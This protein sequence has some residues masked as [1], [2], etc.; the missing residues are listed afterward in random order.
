MKRGLLALAFLLGVSA[1]S[2]RADYVVIVAN[3]GQGGS[4]LTTAGGGGV[5]GGS[6]ARGNILGGAPAG[7][8]LGG[9][10]GA[11]VRGAFGAAGGAAGLPGGVIGAAPG[12]GARGA[13]PGLPGAAMLGGGPPG[14]GVVGGLGAAG[15]PAGPPVRPTFDPDNVPVMI[16]A[17]V[18]VERNLGTTDAAMLEVGRHIKVQHKWGN[19][20]L[21]N[22]GISTV[23]F[24]HLKNNKGKLVA[25]LPFHK[26]YENKVAA[27]RESKTPATA[28]QYVELAE[29]TLGHGMLAKFKEHL[30]KVAEMDKANAKGAAYLQMKAALAKPV[31]RDESAAWRAKLLST[32]YL[33]L[34]SAHYALLHNDPAVAQDRIGRLEE[35]FQLYYYWFAM[36]GLQLPV[37]EERVVAIL[38]SDEKD[39]KRLHQHLDA[40]PIVSDS[41]Y[42]RHE[43]IAVFS[44]KRLDEVYDR[45]EK[46]STPLWSQSFNREQLLKGKY[47]RTA[48]V[49][50]LYEASTLAL[51]LQVMQNDADVAGAT[52]GVSRQLLF[53]SSLLPRGVVAPEWLQFGVG[54]FFETT[55]GSP[56]PTVGEPNFEYLPIYR[57]LDGAKKLPSDRVETIRQVVTD[58]FFRN[59]AANLDEEANLRKARST[60]WSLSYFL[61]RKRLD[62]MQRYVKELSKMPRDLVLD[63]QLLWTAFA[64]AFDALD[65]TGRPDPAALKRLAEDWDKDMKIVPEESAELMKAIREAYQEAATRPAPTAATKPGAGGRPGGGGGGAGGGT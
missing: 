8:N 4:K 11:G 50:D 47:P 26:V 58:S 42:A 16:V 57:S 3:L 43:N 17:V 53:S 23:R 12:A 22:T 38:T 59:P 24:L 41:F 21:A 45:L 31:A 64:R 49:D 36:H 6:V 55:P 18:E 7:A 51:L 15:V 19:S 13:G 27:L 54:S 37:P 2:A 39:F 10:P 61:L 44:T 28:D 46:Y 62:G 56:W 5:L 48:N 9:A 52:H 40:T 25:P 14:P 32:R 33:P 20:I 35:A 30:D 29:W 63:E 60:A 1:I 34:T 65:D